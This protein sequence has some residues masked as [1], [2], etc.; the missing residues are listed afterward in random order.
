MVLWRISNIGLKACSSKTKTLRCKRH[1]RT[2]T[3]LFPPIETP[4]VSNVNA[5]TPHTVS[6]DSEIR[7]KRCCFKPHAV[8]VVYLFLTS[9]VTTHPCLRGR[10]SAL[11]TPQPTKQSRSGPKCHQ[12][13]HGRHDEPTC[14]WLP[15]G[16][17]GKSLFSVEVL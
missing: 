12:P 10:L 3:G 16:L 9:D 4:H 7:G 13:Q 5:V 15:E 17:G 1:R 2:S 14:D 6:I 11:W 8:K